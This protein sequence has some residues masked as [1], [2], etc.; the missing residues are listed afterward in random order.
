MSDITSLD[1]FDTLKQQVIDAIRVRESKAPA[2]QFENDDRIDLASLFKDTSNRRSRRS[3]PQGSQVRDM[4]GREQVELLMGGHVFDV[5]QIWHDQ[6]SD[7]NSE[8]D[9]RWF[10]DELHGVITAELA[11]SI[12]EF[13]E[14]HDLEIDDV[15]ECLKE[16]DDI[17]VRE[18]FD[19]GLHHTSFEYTGSVPMRVDLEANL[20][21][22]PTDALAHALSV[23]RIRPDDWIDAVR[24]M[25]EDDPSVG[26]YF[27]RDDEFTL[28]GYAS[29]LNGNIARLAEH[30][31]LFS[32]DAKD[33][34]VSASALLSK[35]FTDWNTDS[36]ELVLRFNLD[37][38]HI[39]DVSK[40]VARVMENHE[41]D[42]TDI[43]IFGADLTEKGSAEY[44][45][46]LPMLIP[47]NCRLNDLRVDDSE[48]NT[49]DAV[50]TRLDGT[51]GKNL[52]LNELLLHAD[53]DGKTGLYGAARKALDAQ[54]MLPNNLR[55]DVV[56]ELLD[57]DGF[58][59]ERLR[60]R[61]PG[62]RALLPPLDTVI[63]NSL[64]RGC[65][66]LD[67]LRRGT[68]QGERD[69]GTSEARE[70]ASWL[71]QNGADLG[72]RHGDATHGVQAVHLAAK[73]GDFDLLVLMHSHG[74]DLSTTFVPTKADGDHRVGVWNMFAR[75][76]VSQLQQE[77]NSDVG[78]Q[79]NG[80]RWLEEQK[81]IPT[82]PVLDTRLRWVKT[83]KALSIL[84]ND[85]LSGNHLKRWLAG[86]QSPAARESFLQGFLVEALV[87]DAFTT[88]KLC[89]DAGVRMHHTDVRDARDAQTAAEPMSLEQ[90]AIKA[91]GRSPITPA[92]GEAVDYSSALVA[93]DAI[94]EV[95]R[96]AALPAPT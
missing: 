67:M 15:E 61:Y 4:N 22:H 24:K 45:D 28:D 42:R 46:G 13:A 32:A 73:L 81:A 82:G 36:V 10:K 65:A 51:L 18:V 2:W 27:V 8:S 86:C 57:A 55:S 33:A 84:N 71:V 59:A 23:L 62:L 7:G 68:V 58:D 6:C 80:L 77:K 56:K 87:N 92:L 9:E 19:Y 5:E 69:W 49:R 48:V 34:F 72:M 70:R 12:S 83:T 21:A 96:M 37:A 63:G 93:R 76:I 64:D 75:R 16:H 20:M 17:D 90:A 50:A 94:D 54:A 30:G 38:D 43:Q 1:G 39:K 78:D 47:F 25:V 14:K 85:L 53:R 35:M 44:V 52:R 74:A 66:L 91:M 29:E 31:L 88:A 89:L 40:P 3:Q 60:H 11:D 26:G 79:L 41:C 95:M